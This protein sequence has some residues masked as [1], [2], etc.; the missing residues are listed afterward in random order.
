MPASRGLPQVYR[1]RSLR[2]LQDIYDS[3][4]SEAHGS[5]RFRWLVSTCLAA[6][7]GAVAIVVVIVGSLDVRDSGEGLLPTLKRVRDG[8]LPSLTQAPRP[9]DGQPWAVPRTDRLQTASGTGSTR[10]IIHES[11]RQRLLGREKI[12]LKPYA[13]IVARLAPVPQNSNDA[14]PPF[15]P[16]KLYATSTPV[17]TEE[18]EEGGGQR[19]DVALKV[20]DLLGGTLPTED[21]QELDG[22][23]V[24]E[25]VTRSRESEAEPVMRPSFRPE[26]AELLSETPDRV[27]AAQPV[28]PNTTVLQKSVVET[29]DASEDLEG[30]EVRVVK[31]G[32]GDT[33]ARILSRSGADN[34]QARTMAEAARSVLPD[35]GLG[36]GMEVHITVVPSLTQANKVEP[37]RFTVYGD[38]HD[39]K[40]TVARNSA[41]EFVASAQPMDPGIGRAA[42][43][44]SDQPQA[45]SLYSSIYNSALMQNISPDSILQ[46]LRIHAYDTDFRR[47]LRAGDT[48]ELFFDLKN[49]DAVDGPPGE[50]LFSSIMT[51]GETS[52]FYRYRTPD[53]LQPSMIAPS[54]NLGRDC[55]S[56]RVARA[57]LG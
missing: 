2:A 4:H 23:E 56:R 34:L 37:A 33:L 32:R 52:R 7:V 17:G 12:V 14:I 31:V 22:Q 46:I 47:R 53:G 51:G 19:R 18:T 13:R 8:G 1:G 21:G 42:L 26:G 5:G 40:L 55:N 20:L 16:F 35:S 36:A 6:T 28:P 29:D 24:A 54:S 3:D 50:L 57:N 45:S 11:L 49:D 15:N 38:G 25:L 43:S 27:A 39:H 10:Y 30:S 48:V 9:A 41:G 44:D